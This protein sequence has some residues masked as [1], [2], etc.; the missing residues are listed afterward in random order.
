MAKEIQS[1][2]IKIKKDESPQNRRVR[3]MTAITK[4]L[5]RDKLLRQ[6]VAHELALEEHLLDYEQRRDAKANEEVSTGESNT[7]PVDSE[8]E[9]C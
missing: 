5:S 4:L 8:F 1:L 7:E 6:E 3:I 9:E 2:F